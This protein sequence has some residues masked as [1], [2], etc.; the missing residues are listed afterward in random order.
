MLG[1]L[2]S[3]IAFQIEPFFVQQRIFSDRFRPTEKQ[4]KYFALVSSKNAIKS[5]I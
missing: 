3:L 5:R 4:L 2:V 1:L